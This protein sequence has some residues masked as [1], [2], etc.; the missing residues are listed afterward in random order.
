NST[1]ITTSENNYTLSL[2]YDEGWIVYRVRAVGVDLSDPSK[3]I[4][5]NWNEPQSGLVSSI[6][7]TNRYEVTTSLKHE[8]DLNWQYSAT[9]AEQGK[10]KEIVSYYDGSL[11]NRQTVTQIN[12]DN[13]IIVG[14]TI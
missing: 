8:A 10:K 6:S 1:R 13:N 14:E 2:I 7:S 11:R 9:Y 4:F 5:G 12:S 3:L